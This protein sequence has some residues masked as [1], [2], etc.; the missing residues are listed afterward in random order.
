MEQGEPYHEEGVG[1]EA[2]RR[3]G[4]QLCLCKEMP[5]TR[6]QLY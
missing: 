2:P 1:P 6:T 5:T 4:G 3:V